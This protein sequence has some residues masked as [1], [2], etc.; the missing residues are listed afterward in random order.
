MKIPLQWSRLVGGVSDEVDQHGLVNALRDLANQEVNF[1]QLSLATTDATLT[2]AWSDTMPPNSVGDFEFVAIG[3]TADGASVGG[4]RRRVVVQR[5]GTTAVAFVGA[6]ADVIGVDKETVAAWDVAFALDASVPGSLYV[7]V[8]GAAATS[9][10]WRVH[11]QGAV[12]PW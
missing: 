12:L 8:Q 9:I 10:T 7:A 6:G 2:S 1:W 4:Y 3:K 11:V 5:A